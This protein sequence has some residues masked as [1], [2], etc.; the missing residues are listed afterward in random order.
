MSTKPDEPYTSFSEE[1]Q[2]LLNKHSIENGSNT[3][4]FILALY[5]TECLK[6]FDKTMIRR[7]AWYGIKDSIDGNPPGHK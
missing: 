7:S 3:P 6:A 4:D 2:I 1:L 5:L